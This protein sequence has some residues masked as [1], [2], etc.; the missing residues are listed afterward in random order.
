METSAREPSKTS[1]AC[2]RE[3]KER[4]RRESRC[5]T[6]TARSTASFPTSCARVETSPPATEREE[7]PSTGRSSRMKT[8]KSNTRSQACSAWQTLGRTPTEANSSSQRRKRRLDGRHCV[9]GEVV[10]GMDVVRKMEAEGAQSG[11]V[12]KEVKIADC[13]LLE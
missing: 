1:S 3:K 12:E 8:S 6:K 10:E 5:T 4:A 13:G 7:S 2:A 11:T 9:F